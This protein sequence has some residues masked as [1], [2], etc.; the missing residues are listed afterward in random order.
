M[1]CHSCETILSDGTTR[2]PACGA[3]IQAEGSKS[4]YELDDE[5]IPFI[6][7]PQPKAPPIAVSVPVSQGTSVPEQL[8]T[9]PQPTFVAPQ[10]DVAQQ[11][12]I[13]RSISA[14][15]APPLVVL[16]FFLVEGGGFAHSLP[17]LQPTPLTAQAP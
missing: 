11:P 3:S 6:E 4:P 5:V 15:A 7:Y 12:Q 1:Q 14:G 10:P 9:S 8:S 17:K 13:R 2:C 16:A